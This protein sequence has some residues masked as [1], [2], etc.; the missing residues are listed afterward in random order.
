MATK[1]RGGG[2]RVVGWEGATQSVGGVRTLGGGEMCVLRWTE[3]N[4]RDFVTRLR[5]ACQWT[6]Y[7]W[8]FPCSTFGL[9]LTV[10]DWNCGK[11]NCTPKL[12]FPLRAS[13][14]CRWGLQRWVSCIALSISCWC[15]WSLCLKLNTLEL[16]CRVDSK[17]EKLIFPVR[18]SHCA[19]FI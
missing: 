5:M 14:R 6:I 11:R 13:E 4:S 3:R 9:W 16:M 12:A 8:N 18:N 17:T 2:G 15:L 10:G 7:F 1:G 19:Y